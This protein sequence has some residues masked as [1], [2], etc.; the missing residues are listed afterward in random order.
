MKSLFHLIT[1]AIFL[2]LTACSSTMV[3]QVGGPVPCQIQS[4]EQVQQAILESLS[5]EHWEAV[6]S[7]EHIIEAKKKLGQFQALI[8]IAYGYRGFSIEYK[9]SQ[10]M[11]YDI[12]NDTISTRY[13][14]WINALAT[15]INKVLKNE[16]EQLPPIKCLSL[17]DQYQQEE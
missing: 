5:S 2:M 7:S 13:V 12:E 15:S 17:K 10:N 4:T 8:E 9:D 14:K 3:P 1:A 6:A 16:V 11:D